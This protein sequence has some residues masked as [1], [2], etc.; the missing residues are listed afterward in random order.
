MLAN[1]KRSVVKYGRFLPFGR[2]VQVLCKTLFFNWLSLIIS[3]ARH[4]QIGTSPNNVIEN[5]ASVYSM[6]AVPLHLFRILCEIKIATNFQ[7]HEPF[8]SSLFGGSFFLSLVNSF[9]F[10]QRICVRVCV[11]VLILAG[12]SKVRT[13]LPGDAEKGFLSVKIYFFN[14]ISC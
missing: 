7:N 12:F 5:Y 8:P 3:N 2:N 4:V 6:L 1:W 9:D 10:N 11:C 14:F 13:C